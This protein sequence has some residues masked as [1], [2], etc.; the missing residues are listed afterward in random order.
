MPLFPALPVR[1]SQTR[2]P[3]ATHGAHLTFRFD[4]EPWP[5]PSRSPFFFPRP[6]D[7][8]GFS[9][10]GA[11]AAR[12]ANLRAAG[13][14]P[15]PRPVGT[16]TAAGTQYV[17]QILHRA[18]WSRKLPRPAGLGGGLRGA[19]GIPP[20][21]RSAPSGAA[22]GPRPPRPGVGL[23]TPPGGADSGA[24]SL[25]PAARNRVREQLL[26]SVALEVS[27][28]HVAAPPALSPQPR[29]PC[30]GLGL[31]RPKPA[32]CAPRPGPPRSGII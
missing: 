32:P 3:G 25:P 11:P 26:G 31:S 12:G 5:L 22:A 23:R 15:G 24:R 10:H 16:Y 4:S 29:L 17:F 21:Q 18:P 19:F 8:A 13:D 20:G 28:R 9:W 7:G 1:A 2:E 27:S 6:P 14:Q 30:S